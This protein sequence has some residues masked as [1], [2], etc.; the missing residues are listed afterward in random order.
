MRRQLQR[1]HCD[2]QA[3]ER[4]T[5]IALSWR[6]GVRTAWLSRHVSSP[7]GNRHNATEG[8]SGYTCSARFTAP[9]FQLLPGGPARVIDLLFPAFSERRLQFPGAFTTAQMNAPGQYQR[10]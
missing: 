7:A 4:T 3:E 9:A 10:R 8:L 6:G 5:G 2:T 1:N